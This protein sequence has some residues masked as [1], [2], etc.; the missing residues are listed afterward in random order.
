[1]SLFGIIHS[2]L[3]NSAIYLPWNLSLDSTFLTSLPYRFAAG[4]AM[5]GL[6]I[7]T[8]ARMTAGQESN[9]L[10]GNPESN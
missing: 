4:Y 6:V 9:S 10:A 5:A 3:D 2:V 1:L 8:F 7:L